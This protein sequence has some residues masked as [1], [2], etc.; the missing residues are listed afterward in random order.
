MEIRNALDSDALVIKELLEQL[1]YPSTEEFLRQRLNE[2]SAHPDHLDVVFVDGIDVSGFLSMHF[3]PQIAFDS[4]YAVISY[5]IVDQRLRSKGIGKSLEEFAVREARSRNC[6]RIFLHSN[7]RR[8]DAH[9]FYLKQGY[10][11]YAKT[12][13]KYLSD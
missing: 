6:T 3:I 4:S 7:V 2:L 12:F 8:A 11:E 5:L 1:G 9:R 10:E 13:I